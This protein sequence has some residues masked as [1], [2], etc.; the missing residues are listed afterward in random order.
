MRVHRRLGR[1]LRFRAIGG[2]FGE[3]RIERETLSGVA[4]RTERN[5][6]QQLQQADGVVARLA[7][8]P[9]L[10]IPADAG[11]GVERPVRRMDERP[12]Q[13]AV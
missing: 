12:A 8:H 10:V 11:Q 9:R 6:A 2:R 1:H 7:N 4:G 13:A 5:P 3:V